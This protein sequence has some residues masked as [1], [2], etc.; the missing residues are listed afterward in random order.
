[1]TRLG[2]GANWILLPLFALPDMKIGSPLLERAVVEVCVSLDAGVILVKYH[3]SSRT[4]RV[5]HALGPVKD[6]FQRLRSGRR[7]T[8]DGNG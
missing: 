7:L 3:A 1:M 5:V 6:L 8:R 2:R 4:E